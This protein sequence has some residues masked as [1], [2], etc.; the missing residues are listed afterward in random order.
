MSTLKKLL[1]PKLPGLCLSYKDKLEFGSVNRDAL[2][3]FVLNNSFRTYYFEP[4]FKEVRQKNGRRFLQ[5]FLS[6]LEVYTSMTDW[7]NM[8]P[9][10]NPTQYVPSKKVTEKKVDL[11]QQ[12]SSQVN[13]AIKILPILGTVDMKDSTVVGTLIDNYSIFLEL[14][15]ENPK[16]MIVPTLTEDFVWHAHMT[17]H[18]AYKQDMNNIFGKVLQHRIGMSETELKNYKV[19]S[20]KLRQKYLESKKLTSGN[21]NSNN[22]TTLTSSGSSCSSGGCTNLMCPTNLWS[23]IN[24]M[25]QFNPM[26]PYYHHHKH[27]MY[28]DYTSPR[29]DNESS[30][31]SYDGSCGSSCSSCSSSCGSSCGGD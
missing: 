12:H 3:I 25:N 30:N 17:D 15:K 21:D 5:K 18:E 8:L 26:S 31:D 2:K 14:C 22:N 11:L 7:I 20:N 19:E 29:D 9:K 10:M 13:F 23:P 1:T 24:P 27:H 4:T 28:N 16:V 6:D